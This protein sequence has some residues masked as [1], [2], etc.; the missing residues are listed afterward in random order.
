VIKI[1]TGKAYKEMGK[2]LEY[3]QEKISK[4]IEQLENSYGNIDFCA[5]EDTYVQYIKVIK[6][7]EKCHGILLLTLHRKNIPHVYYPPRKIKQTITTDGKA[8]KETMMK[9]IGEKFPDLR[10]IDDNHA[11]SIGIALTYI[12]IYYR[13]RLEKIFE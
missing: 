5:I 11:D 1:P 7:L 2:K 8:S 13:E 6:T 9:Q 4:L 10:I 12:T 3:I